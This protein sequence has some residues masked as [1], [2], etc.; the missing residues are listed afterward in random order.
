MFEQNTLIFEKFKGNPKFFDGTEVENISQSKVKEDILHF[1]KDGTAQVQAIVVD[2]EGDL[3]SLADVT[4]GN[5]IS[6]EIGDGTILEL[7]P[8]FGEDL[9]LSISN[10]LS[11]VVA[12]CEQLCNKQISPRSMSVMDIAINKLYE[13]KKITP[14]MYEY[15]KVLDTSRYREDSEINHICEGIKRVCRPDAKT[16]S[17]ISPDK[18][19]NIYDLHAVP[20]I[21][22]GAAYIFCLSD[23]FHQMQKN[24]Q[25][26]IRTCVYL[27]GV[28][29]LLLFESGVDVLS[30]LLKRARP[31]NTCI[32]VQNKNVGNYWGN[33]GLLCHFGNFQK[34]SKTP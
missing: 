25:N 21:D 4:D 12:L 5:V 2:T 28:Q 3:L 18:K 9:L 10:N 17:G 33:T 31:F 14:N 8:H 26:G 29:C 20:Q 32:Y 24:Y 11:F 30:M 15:Y 7:I 22:L 6:R 34:L 23:I 1:V 13:Q 16:V 27:N 19:V